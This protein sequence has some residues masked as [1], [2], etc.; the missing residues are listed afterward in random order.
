MLYPDC[1]TH[2]GAHRIF[3]V[4]LVPS[5]VAPFSFA[6][7]SQTRKID[8]R[9]TLSRTTSVFSSSA[10]LFGKLKRDMLSFRESALQDNTKLLPISENANE[11]SANDAKLFKSQ[12]IQRMVN[13]RD[14]SLPSSTDT[15]TSSEPT[16]NQEK[17]RV[18]FSSLWLI[19][20]SS[21][22][23]ASFLTRIKCIIYLHAGC[24]HPHAQCSSGK[25]SS[26]LLMDSGTVT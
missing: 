13:T 21:D 2:L 18:R 10:A 12:T 6:D 23:A 24:C 22:C 8:L 14:I 25:S 26:F 9:R 5:S 3:S 4:V 16:S 19:V 7:T 17:V 15:S 20:S 11:I 1:E